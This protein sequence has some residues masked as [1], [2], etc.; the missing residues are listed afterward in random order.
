MRPE[1]REEKEP[2]KK[3]SEGG[4]QAGDLANAKVLL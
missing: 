2:V 1:K 4:F 3:R